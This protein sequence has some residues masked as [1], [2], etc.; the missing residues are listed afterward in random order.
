MKK[1]HTFYKSKKFSAFLFISLIVFGIRPV[2]ANESIGTDTTNRIFIIEVDG[3]YVYTTQGTFL[4]TPAKIGQP[5][6]VGHTVTTGNNSSAQLQLDGDVLLIMDAN[7]K[8]AIASSQWGTG[9][10][11]T[12]QR[13]SIFVNS[14]THEPEI[15]V[16]NNSIRTLG[17]IF[18][19]SI[20]HDGTI[21][22]AMLDGQSMVNGTIL[23]AESI[24]FIGDE[25]IIHDLQLEE[26]NLFTLQVILNFRESLLMRGRVS[27]EMIN[28]APIFIERRWLEYRQRTVALRNIDTTGVILCAW[29]A[30][31]PPPP[32]RVI[33]WSPAPP[34]PP[35]TPP[36]MTTPPALTFAM[37]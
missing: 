25:V 1:F 18:A 34:L 35:F 21:T 26:M 33:E 12:L 20:E 27:T 6:V 2:I 24:M 4:E 22:I 37:N 11:I 3:D 28:R 17:A 13:G 8:I 16:A 32:P 19:V 5:L 15:R 29:T 9:L 36:P 7:S 31:N 14:V 10:V 23:P 30:L